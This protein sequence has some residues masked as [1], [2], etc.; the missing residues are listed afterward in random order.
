[1]SY[2]SNYLLEQHILSLFNHTDKTLEYLFTDIREISTDTLNKAYVANRKIIEILVENEIKERED[3]PS[4]IVDYFTNMEMV[5]A[6]EIAERNK[7]GE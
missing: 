5:F 3:I 2:T 4:L 1:M 7:K 6:H